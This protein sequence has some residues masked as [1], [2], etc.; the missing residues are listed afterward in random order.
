MADDVKQWLAGPGERFLRRV[1]LREGQVVLDFGCRRCTYS[2]PAAHVVGP[3]GAVLAVDKNTEALETC[4]GLSERGRL[5]NV[6]T[7]DTGGE[8][9]IPLEDESV[10]VVLLYDVIHLIGWVKRGG[11]TVRKSCRDDRRVLLGEVHR[12]ARDGALLSLYCPHL[13]SHTDVESDEDIRCEVEQA[14]FRFDEDFRTELVHDDVLTAGR[15]LN[16]R[17]VG[18]GPRL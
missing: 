9:H 18:S 2:I 14:G 15:V 17:K 1:G 10:D 4:D 7:I 3:G 16:F 13:K 11:T 8:V 5:D 12:V 6:K